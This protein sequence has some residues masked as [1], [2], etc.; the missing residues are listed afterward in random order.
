MCAA[1]GRRRWRRGGGAAL[2]EAA[3]FEPLGLDGADR[4]ARQP[5]LVRLARADLPHQVEEHLPPTTTHTL[6]TRHVA[7]HKRCDPTPR[8]ACSD[9]IL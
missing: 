9:A 1:A 8:Q 2:E 4:A 5:R 3:L 7:T 6:A